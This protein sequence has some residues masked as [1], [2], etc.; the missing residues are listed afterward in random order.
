MHHS[1]DAQ[2][3]KQR[4]SQAKSHTC[5]QTLLNLGTHDRSVRPETECCPAGDAKD[6]VAEMVGLTA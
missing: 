3:Q 2:S 6:A 4:L 5:I 1:G